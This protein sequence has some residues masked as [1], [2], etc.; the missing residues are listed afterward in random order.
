[1]IISNDKNIHCDEI[2]GRVVLKSAY[3]QKKTMIKNIKEIKNRNKNFIQNLQI[4]LNC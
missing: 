4:Q 1:M 2:Q 3:L